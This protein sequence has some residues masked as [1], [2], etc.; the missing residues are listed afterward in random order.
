M[1]ARLV[2]DRLIIHELPLKLDPLQIATQLLPANSCGEATFVSSVT[3]RYTPNV[4][5]ETPGQTVLA[6]FTRGIST[7]REA[8]AAACKVISPVW[9]GASLVIPKD[10]LRF[11]DWSRSTQP[12]LWLSCVNV[13]GIVDVS[14]TIKCVVQFTLN[15]MRRVED[16]LTTINTNCYLGPV[17]A[18]FS[19]TGSMP[20]IQFG[21]W[22]GGGNTININLKDGS[23]KTTSN[24]YIRTPESRDYVAVRYAI[25][26]ADYVY[27]T[28]NK[29]YSW[30]S[31]SYVL[32]KY[33]TSSPAPGSADVF[34]TGSWRPIKGSTS[35]W[36]EVNAKKQSIVSGGTTKT[37]YLPCSQLILY[38]EYP[39]VD[40]FS[41]DFAP[42][43][44][45]H[46]GDLLPCPAGNMSPNQ[47]QTL[48]LNH[49]RLQMAWNAGWKPVLTNSP[50]AV[51]M[52]ENAKKEF[53]AWPT[54][55]GN[56]SSRGTFSD[57]KECDEG[58]DKSDD[59]EHHGEPG[60]TP[61][62][63]SV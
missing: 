55:C 54:N 41:P 61:I 43:I 60:D 34:F 21:T 25:G 31:Y 58:Q 7:V 11:E 44:R 18:G 63:H 24:R 33:T 47:E 53:V 23:G 26:S 51:E 36:A 30:K 46:P 15:P 50:L 8:H 28:A 27:T 57:L 49:S 37:E 40:I 59:A 56:V 3:V 16:S 62:D 1:S 14:C 4:S 48:P 13:Q 6:V 38:Y 10:L 12:S 42:A 20:A 35:W 22:S 5:S 17:L 45:V 39:G 2:C 52:F 19:F 32:S 9:K 29:K